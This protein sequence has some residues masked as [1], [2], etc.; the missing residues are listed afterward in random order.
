MLGN[1]HGLNIPADFTRSQCVQ[2]LANTDGKDIVTKHVQSVK[3]EFGVNYK[4]IAEAMTVAEIADDA[5]TFLQQLI[6][7]CQS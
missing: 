7:M 4:Q 3:A 6:E 1:P 2:T 5:R